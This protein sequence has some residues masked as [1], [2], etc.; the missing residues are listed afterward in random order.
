VI[1]GTS[2]VSDKKQEISSVF[3]EE[4]FVYIG[5]RAYLDTGITKEIG[6]EL[7]KRKGQLVDLV[8]EPSG[9]CLEARITEVEVL[10]VTR[11]DE[12]LD[13]SFYRFY[14][15]VVDGAEAIDDLRAEKDRYI[16]SETA[17]KQHA[18]HWGTERWSGLRL[19]IRDKDGTVLH[20]TRVDV[21]APSDDKT[22]SK[23]IL[24]Y[25]SYS[26]TK[27]F[28]EQLRKEGFYTRSHCAKG[29]DAL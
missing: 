14:F 29:G 12:V 8:I 25:G 16:D 5:A 26:H 20:K 21:F 1:Y 4:P 24:V 10:P 27:E 19:S 3:G 9:Q 7:A 22:V 13:G 11:K 17:F 18:A 15:E 2:E 23:K 6:D 28:V